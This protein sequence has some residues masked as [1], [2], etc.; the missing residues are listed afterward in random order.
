MSGARGG[1]REMS[2]RKIK[3]SPQLVSMCL[4][5]VESFKSDLPDDVRARDIYWEP[6]ENCYFLLVESAEFSELAEGEQIPIIAPIF[7]KT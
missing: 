1:V 7:T 6:R 3:V 2:I 4:K 5:G